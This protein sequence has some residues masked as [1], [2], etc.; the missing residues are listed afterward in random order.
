MDILITCLICASCVGGAC[1]IAA[2]QWRN[3]FTDSINNDR[4]TDLIKRLLNARQ[5]KSKT[6][7]DRVELTEKIINEMQVHIDS[8]EFVEELPEVLP[9]NVRVIG[10]RLKDAV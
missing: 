2:K 9:D 6:L 1:F 8:L 4:S 10:G 3:R 5:D 7:S